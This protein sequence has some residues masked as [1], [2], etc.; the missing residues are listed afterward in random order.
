[1]LKKKKI[2]I[3]MVL[4][5]VLAQKQ[6]QSFNKKKTKTSSLLLHNAIVHYCNYNMEKYNEDANKIDKILVLKDDGKSKGQDKGHH[7]I[8]VIILL[9]TFYLMDL[10]MIFNFIFILQSKIYILYSMI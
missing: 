3:M 5:K 1:M 8:C 2:L 9:C 6:Q 7:E 10:N 4:Y